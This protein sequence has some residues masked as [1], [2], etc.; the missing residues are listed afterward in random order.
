MV[1]DGTHPTKVT[2]F[3]LT[4]P[5]PLPITP[6]NN[7]NKQQ[8]LDLVARLLAVN[9]A[10]RLTL[11]AALAHPYLQQAETYYAAGEEEK[12][13]SS[14]GKT[15][16]DVPLPPPRAVAA[17]LWSPSEL[18]VLEGGQELGEEEIRVGIW[19]A[20]HAFRA[21]ASA[22]AAPAASAAPQGRV[23]GVVPA[24]AAAWAAVP[25]AVDGGC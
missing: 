6:T 7:H 2:A 1:W 17:S 14:S 16:G 13:S 11:D 10:R 24:A 12:G 23:V 25:M 9:P 22:F 8:A 21:A 5:P 4:K 15:V 19:E 3:D 18:S 20:M